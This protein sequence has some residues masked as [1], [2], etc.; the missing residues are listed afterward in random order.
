MTPLCETLTEKGVCLI[1]RFLGCLW[2][3]GG[4]RGLSGLA[5]ARTA[6]ACLAIPSEGC[7]VCESGELPLSQAQI[8][9]GADMVFMPQISSCEILP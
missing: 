9:E 4:C 8:C 6:R 2:P 5:M 1:L 7:G 3:F